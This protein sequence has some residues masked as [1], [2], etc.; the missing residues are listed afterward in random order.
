MKTDGNDTY[1][2]RTDPLSS[3]NGAPS[4]SVGGIQVV[5]LEDGPKVVEVWS[6]KFVYEED[7]GAVLTMQVVDG[8]VVEKC[9]SMKNRWH[10]EMIANEVKNREKSAGNIWYYVPSR[11][12][13]STLG[14]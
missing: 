1:R 2:Q 13:S 5:V 6:K 12:R 14:M 4:G 9:V 10:P 7:P 11:S 3:G 8:E